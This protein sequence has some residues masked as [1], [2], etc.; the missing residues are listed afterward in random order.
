MKVVSICRMQDSGTLNLETKRVND[1]KA[2]IVEK[3]SG[4]TKVRRG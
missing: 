1:F 4:E 3:R 2:K